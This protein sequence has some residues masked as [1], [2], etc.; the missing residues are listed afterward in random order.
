MTPPTEINISARNLSVSRLTLRMVILLSLAV[1]SACELE[2]DPEPDSEPDSE[3][4]FSPKIAH[5]VSTLEGIYHPLS[6]DPLHWQDEELGMLDSLAGSTILAL[7]EATHGTG[8]FFDAKFRIFRYLAENH[9]YRIFAI[10]ADPGECMVINEA[11]QEGR[12]EEIRSLMKEYMFF[13]TW[14]TREVEEMLSW[15]CRFNQGREEDDKI[16]Y[17]GFDCQYHQLNSELLLEYLRNAEFTGMNLSDSLLRRLMFES[18][19]SPDVYTDEKYEAD[20]LDLQ[21]LRDSMTIFHPELA[22]ASGETSFQ[23]YYHLAEILSQALDLRHLAYKEINGTDVRD[24]YMAE[25][26]SWYVEHMAPPI[27]VWAHN[28]HISRR[29]SYEV[30]MM[31]FYLDEKF[32]DRYA[33]IG[34]QFAMGEFNAYGIRNMEF[35]PLV[36]Q[37]L[38]VVPDSTSLPWIFSQAEEDIFFVSTNVLKGENCWKEAM[39]RGLR[40][41]N[42]G[43]AYDRVLEHCYSPF[44]SESFDH[45]IYIEESTHSSLL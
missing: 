29:N 22:A 14:K 6:S 25:N 3:A 17:V 38:S 18:E 42:I 35:T 36:A 21:L 40:Y 12:E 24:R 32:G 7:G 8:E 39:I 16:R 28:F 5:M 27:F 31:G 11:I 4:Q 19:Q 44:Y 26:V 10:E 13:W 34:F 2:P 45:L 37:T 43:A 15:M 41:I 23:Q 33:N 20:L 30:N 9:G 1:I